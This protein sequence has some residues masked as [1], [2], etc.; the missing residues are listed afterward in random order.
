MNI[1]PGDNDGN[2]DYIDKHHFYHSMETLQWSL[3]TGKT[4]G[5]K[6][7]TREPG[8]YNIEINFTGDIAAGKIDDLRVHVYN[9][10]SQ[11]MR[12]VD[13][14]HKK[15]EMICCTAGIRPKA[16]MP[17]DGGDHRR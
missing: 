8:I 11:Y 17:A 1:R 5:F 9:N 2:A 12:C 10:P 3:G 6:V 13:T 16:P 7:R 4:F 14:I 15:K